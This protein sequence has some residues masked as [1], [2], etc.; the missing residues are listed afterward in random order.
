VSLS[1]SQALWSYALAGSSKG[2]TR[3]IGL[4]DDEFDVDVVPSRSGVGTDLICLFNKLFCLCL[5]DARKMDIKLNRELKFIVELTKCDMARYLDITELF[6][7]LV[8]HK[9]DR[10]GETCRVA[11]SKQ[12]LR[13]RCPRLAWSTHFVRYTQIEFHNA[14]R[15]FDVSVSPTSGGR[16]G[17][18]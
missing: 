12:L 8:G 17:C 9:T 10:T 5:I 14:I 1:S 7:L 15:T 13:I 16:H 18:I 2:V 3:Q 11:S 6:V 4:H